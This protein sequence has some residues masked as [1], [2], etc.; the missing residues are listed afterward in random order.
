MSEKG[1][2]PWY[3][4][5]RAGDT[6]HPLRKGKDPERDATATDWGPFLAGVW[7]CERRPAWHVR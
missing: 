6:R 2:V 3:R 7:G 1:G 4:Y 5:A